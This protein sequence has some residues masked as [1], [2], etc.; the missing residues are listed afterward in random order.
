MANRDETKRA[1]EFLEQKVNGMLNDYY[2]AKQR[3][4]PLVSVDKKG[5]LRVTDIY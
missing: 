1:L 2:E 4:V 5:C 3:S